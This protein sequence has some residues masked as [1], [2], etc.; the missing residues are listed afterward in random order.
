MYTRRHIL[1]FFLFISLSLFTSLSLFADDS[2]S[3]V[4][5]E[6]LLNNRI[7][8]ASLEGE[9]SAIIHGCVNVVTGSFGISSTDLVA[10]HGV[11]PLSVE[12]SSLSAGDT[13][14]VLG[15]LWTLNHHSRIGKSSLKKKHRENDNYDVEERGSSLSFTGY[16]EENGLD[17]APYLLKKVVVNTSHGVISGQTNM[18]TM[19][20]TKSSSRDFELKFGT[21]STRTYSKDLHYRLVHEKKPSGNETRYHYTKPETHLDSVSLFNRHE[22]NVA[23]LH[24][25]LINEKVIDKKG[26][27]TIKT[28]DG[29]SVDYQFAWQTWSDRYL[30]GKVTRSDGY[31]ESFTYEDLL[32]LNGHLHLIQ[33][34][35]KPHDQRLKVDYYTMGNT[36]TI[37][38][39]I[40]ITDPKD[41]RLY[42][43]NRIW[44]PAGVDQT[45]RPIYQFV[46]HLNRAKHK[47]HSRKELLDGFCDVYNA[48]EHKTRYVFNKY[49]R[50]TAVE[51]FI[52]NEMYASEHL[53]WGDQESSDRTE[54]MMRALEQIAHGFVFANT[55]EYDRRGNITKQTLYGNLTGN[56]DTRPQID[57]SKIVEN[58]CESHQKNCVYSKDGFNL[59]LHESDGVTATTYQY[60]PD[61]NLLIA[62]FEGD[63]PSCRKRYFYTYDE[64][65][66]LTSETIDNGSGT[67]IDD[68]SGVTTRYLTEYKQ[69]VVYPAAYPVEIANSYIDINTGAKHLTHRVVNTYNDLA[70]IT[71]QEHYDSNN[72]Y[73]YTLLWDYDLMGN[74]IRE[75]NALGHVTTRTYDLFGKCLSEEGQRCKTLFI[76][77]FMNR[78]IRKEEVH[79]DGERLVTSNRYDL[80][81]NCLATIDSFGNETLYE[82][83][84]FGRMTKITYPLSLHNGKLLRPSVTKEY[85]VLGNATKETNA[86][87][88]EKR[89]KYNI[90]NQITD[91]AYADGTTEHYRYSLNGLPVESKLRDGTRFRY[92]NDQ[93]GRVVKTEVLSAS[94]EVLSTTSTVYDSFHKLSETDSMGFVT[95]YD[96]Y[97]DGNVK[98]VQREGSLTQYTYDSMQ[99]Q[100]TVREYYGDDLEEVIVHRKKYNHLNA[101]TDEIVEEANGQVISHISYEH[102]SNGNIC[103]M[104][105]ETRQGLSVTSTIY[106]SHGTARKVTDAEGNETRTETNRNFINAFGQH[107]MQTVV[108]DPMGNMTIVE[109]DTLQ[110]NFRTTRKNAFGKLLQSVE[111]QYDVNG[112]CCELTDLVICPDGTE[113][114]QITHME[115]DTTDHLIASFEAYGSANQK[116]CRIAYDMYGR[117]ERVTKADGVQL[118]HAYDEFGRL[119]QLSSSDNTIDYFYTYDL[120]HHPVQVE[121][122]IRHTTTVREYDSDLRLSK[123]TLN[124]LSLTYAYDRTGRPIEVTL[125]DQSGIAYSYRS[126]FL[127]K[128]TRIDSNKNPIYT[129]TYQYERG[130]LHSA[131]LIEN[132]G[133][134]LYDYD[135]LG[136]LTAIQSPHCNE[137]LTYDSAGNLTGQ[138]LNGNANHYTYNDLYQLTS[139]NQHTYVYD[140][141]YNRLAKDGVTHHVNELNQLLDDGTRRYQYDCNGNLIEV[142]G[143]G[144]VERFT[145]DALDRLIS[146]ENENSK[147]AY[148]YD[149]N[150]RRLIKTLYKI[151][152]G[153]WKE[154]STARYLYHDQNEIGA[155]DLSGNIVELR[156]LGNGLGAEIGAAVSME[157]NGCVYIPVHDHNGNVIA[158]LDKSGNV[159][160]EYRYSSFGERLFERA[161]TPWG[162]SSKRFDEES[163]YIYF[164][165]RYYHSATGR[166]LTKDPIGRDGGPN[167]YAYV[168]NNPLTHF[169]LYGLFAEGGYGSYFG[170]I[171]NGVGSVFRS[172][173]RTMFGGLQAIGNLVRAQF[174]IPVLRDSIAAFTHFLSN[175]TLDGYQ[176][177]HKTHSSCERMYGKE[178]NPK[179][180]IVFVNGMNNTWDDAEFAS[181]RVSEYHGNIEIIRTFNAGHGVASGIAQTVVL[182]LGIKTNSVQ[183]C[184][185]TINTAFSLLDSDGIID[186]YGF[187]QGGRL[188]DRLRPYFTKEQLSRIHVTTLGSAKIIENYGF[189]SVR[190]YVNTSDLIPYIADPLGVIKSFV[191]NKYHLEFLPSDDFFGCGHSFMSNAY[192]QIIQRDGLEYQRKYAIGAP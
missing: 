40:K 184:V 96:Y 97:P 32:P 107:V 46:Y 86:K 68:L 83:D 80:A 71:R 172:F 20:L 64:N 142:C 50:I 45:L 104:A 43:V 119:K 52:G 4:N 120:H 55:Y 24:Y 149:E 145:Y 116:V 5:A 6:Q 171:M 44:A 141:H 101:V 22:E 62:K 168:L 103:K 144:G 185:D 118:L 67:D 191:S 98:S 123:E 138:K 18:K 128:V 59:L 90:R 49:Q 174:P 162:F 110:R 15:E 131:K 151:E 53:Y 51:R 100:E 102:D 93:L 89:I 47:H 189:G 94:G 8:L 36:P 108:T 81:G 192:Q 129:H 61:S 115:Y 190:N 79:H 30:L 135:R 176:M 99:R 106:D 124:G 127:D 70:K 56:N 152:S 181:E 38:G 69:S 114:K 167:L 136:R 92:T 72:E 91:V 74:P 166:W 9:P 88:I 133:T 85:D 23:S 42:R 54:L 182:A 188:I 82:Y 122:R 28:G 12:R 14:G 33:E 19:R 25:G 2:D 169:D 143:D 39:R 137:Q 34:W 11:N 87:G 37:V 66:A 1:C 161:I 154:Q 126:K 3:N 84:P 132:G 109:L 75:V 164:G 139:E 95:N 16:D 155:C 183:A 175:G 148:V 178:R 105:N 170:S 146:Y 157:M 63:E 117:K 153:V 27:C 134:L 130:Q 158:L 48:L 26:T 150:N 186:L 140:S 17:I 179:R 65:A 76:H 159:V 111:K 112:N 57:D 156:L 77:D 58:G 113:K 31:Y 35:K 180:A 147:A 13:S 125:P 29:R 41:P 7:A 187:S 121:D 73:Q 177:E 160:E 60:Q 173:G 165:R 163:G 21:G 78:L 10:H